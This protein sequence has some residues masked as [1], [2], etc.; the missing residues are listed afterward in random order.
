MSEQQKPH[1]LE[2]IFQYAQLEKQLK[3]VLP[4]ISRKLVSDLLATGTPDRKIAKVIGRS[5]SYVKGI[6]SG[7]RS[8]NAQLIV[9]LV[10]FASSSA[11]GVQ[12]GTSEK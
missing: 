11:Q 9:K 10:K 5:P 1:L 3:P 6:A 8:L 4:Q 12:S 2:L 7:E